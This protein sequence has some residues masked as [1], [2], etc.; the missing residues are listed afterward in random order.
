MN[1]KTIYKINKIR[2]KY[3]FWTLN[4]EYEVLS[5]HLYSYRLCFT[6]HQSMELT[7]EKTNLIIESSKKIDILKNEIETEFDINL[8]FES[9]TEKGKGTTTYEGYIIYFL[10]E[11]ERCIVHSNINKHANDLS[12]GL[13]YDY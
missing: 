11:N 2:E 3:S 9:V 13:N 4:S 7:A 12:V 5:I 10:Q 6:P 8:M 1:I